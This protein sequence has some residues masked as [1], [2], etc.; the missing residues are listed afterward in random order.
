MNQNK[1]FQAFVNLFNYKTYSEAQKK[2]FTANLINVFERYEY[3]AGHS[4]GEELDMW[5]EILAKWHNSFGPKINRRVVKNT[6]HHKDMKAQ[7][8]EPWNTIFNYHVFE[9]GLE[10]NNVFIWPVYTIYEMADNH[11]DMKNK[12]AFRCLKELHKTYLHFISSINHK[13]RDMKHI[14]PVEAEAPKPRV[15]S[16]ME[17]IGRFDIKKYDRKKDKRGYY[18]GLIKFHPVLLDTY[19][20]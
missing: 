1:V 14:A 15:Y 20:Y 2:F 13:Y 4:Q 9:G 17:S 12:E 19:L 11:P 7:F 6:L 8:S 3:H 10:K 18:H 16:W 5:Y